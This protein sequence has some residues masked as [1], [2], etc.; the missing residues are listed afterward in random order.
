MRSQGVTRVPFVW[1]WPDG[2]RSCAIVTHDVETTVGRDRCSWLMD[3]DD[4]YDI[5]SAF[6][7]VPEARYDV[8]RRFLNEIK[9][10]GFEIDV[11]DLN[12]AVD[13]FSSHKEF[14]RRA[15][16]IN[17]YIRSFGTRGFRSGSLFRQPAW[18]DALDITYDMSIPNVGHLRFNGADAAR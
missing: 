11:H 4:Q 2:A 12:H 15:L 14:L 17:E 13:L 7:V 18:Y 16:R 6:D 3:V 5:K 1:F 8:S 10:R 9:E